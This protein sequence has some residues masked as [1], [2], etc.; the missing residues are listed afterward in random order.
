M[1]L[2]KLKLHEKNEM[3]LYSHQ[4]DVFFRKYD[5]LKIIVFK[6]FMMMM[7]SA[8]YMNM[9]SLIQ[10]INC[11]VTG[12]IKSLSM[13]ILT[14]LPHEIKCYPGR[15]R[16]DCSMV[17]VSNLCNILWILVRLYKYAYT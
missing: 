8:Y 4:Q 13:D 1:C 2:L 14:Q 10:A 3:C 7:L 9:I 6:S 15:M 12:N 5:K 17:Q 11:L 16:E